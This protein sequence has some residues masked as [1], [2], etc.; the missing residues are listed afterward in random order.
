[1]NSRLSFLISVLVVAGY[2]CTAQVRKF[3]G[4]VV[5]NTNDTIR[6]QI[7][8]WGPSSNA[9][10]VYLI[11]TG[12]KKPTVYDPA[13]ANAYFFGGTSYESKLV[14]TIT[15]EK[16]QLFV[17]PLVKGR[18]T[19]YRNN[20]TLFATRDSLGFSLTQ[21]RVRSTR[22]KRLRGLIKLLVADC[23]SIKGDSIKAISENDLRAMAREYNACTGSPSIEHDIPTEKR[24]VAVGVLAGENVST[25]KMTGDVM[26]LTSPYTAYNYQPA[27]SFMFGL[28]AD[29]GRYDTPSLYLEATYFNTN[30]HSTAVNALRTGDKYYNV[31]YLRV[32]AGPRIKF[33]N[34][35][36]HAYIG[37]GISQMIATKFDVLEIIKTSTT[38]SQ[39]APSV[40]S[41]N[42]QG[43]WISVGLQ[44]RIARNL[45]F[46]IEGR[47]EQ[48][49]GFATPQTIVYG[50]LNEYSVTSSSISNKSVHLSIIF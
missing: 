20:K 36:F 44:R 50:S 47:L 33:R 42:S 24:R 48:V 1:M 13:A 8:D 5:T 26:S 11:K 35:L 3:D 43:F 9:Q 40:K 7:E 37:V 38:T 45:A 2:C 21:G 15:G 34:R 23:K 46:R 31:S 32:A 28:S 39:F 12:A 14:N 18:L 19:L 4:Y 49:T 22:M 41:T 16:Q 17:I 25:L 10:R 29:F 30:F 6:G 27:H